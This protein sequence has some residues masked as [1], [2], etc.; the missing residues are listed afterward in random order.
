MDIKRYVIVQAIKTKQN[1][2]IPI[3]DERI[4][5]TKTK[6]VGSIITLKGEHNE[7][8][9]VVECIYDLKTKN[10]E[11]GVELNYYPNE[12]DLEFKKDQTILF[13]K[14]HRKLAEAIISEIVYEEYEM[15]IK[16]GDKLDE[17]WISVFKDVEIDKNTLYCIKEWKPF[18]V[19]DNGI[20]IEWN[21]KLYHKFD[22]NS[23]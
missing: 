18:Y 22:N 23:K 4:V 14:S 10:I 5:F 17:Y 1:E 20:K 11:L 7:Y 21:Y 9:S 12:N 3:W 19:L 16:R 8:Y 13:E 15:V 6:E 2:L